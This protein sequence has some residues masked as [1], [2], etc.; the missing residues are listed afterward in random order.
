MRILHTADWHF[1]RTL[2]GR[3][4]MKEQVAFM[5][6]LLDVVRDE[7]VDIVLIAGD[8]YD[9]VNP[10][11]A[12]EQLFYEGIA[13]L[14][15]GGKRQVAVISGNHDHPDRLAAS[16]PLAAAQGITLV[17]SPIAECLSIGVSRTGELARVIALPYPSESRLKELLSD[18]ADE[19][20]LRGQYSDKV[21]SLI[22]RQA[23]SF[24]SSTVN[25]LMS[26]LYVLGG[27]E[28]ES[29]RP[30]Q[31]GGAYTVDTTALDCGAQ[32]VAL[33]H[34]HRPQ[35]V[36]AASPM[37]YSGSPLAYSFSEAGQAKSVTLLDLAPGQAAEPQEIFL[38]S[39]RPLVSW[40]AKEGIGQVYQWLDEKRDANAWIDLE[41]SMTSAMSM[42][43]IQSLRKAY[44][45]F[46][47]IRPIYPEMEAARIA[48]PK[49]A[50]SMEEHF[51][52]FYARQTGGAQPEQELVRLFLEL[53][54]DGAREEAS[55][56]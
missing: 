48:L 43:Q 35:M 51:T 9:S 25:L 18:V 26:H 4:R 39:G 1:G 19:E 36:K 7:R 37:R 41:I 46:I 55:G 27:Q 40:K 29:E 15:D 47:H 42:E 30:I 5:D 16:G 10:P 3:S 44:D 50:L 28:T 34:L 38:T 32:Y 49:K 13:R 24:E 53:L 14:S 11:A 54:E 8:I 12:A 45:G 6:E 21:A 31:V 52:R 23:L 17:G 2:E 56:E 22:R 33:G 20:V